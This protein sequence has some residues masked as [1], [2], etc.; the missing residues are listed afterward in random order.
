MKLILNGAEDEK[1]LIEIFQ[2]FVENR[3]VNFEEDRRIIRRAANAPFTFCGK[4]VNDLRNILLVCRFLN[5]Y[6][7]IFSNSSA[8]R[9]HR[10]SV[11]FW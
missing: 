3:R 5:F 9:E 8:I 2:K 11:R 10:I 6:Y 1:P 4:L 7:K